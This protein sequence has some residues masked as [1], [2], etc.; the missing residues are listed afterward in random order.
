MSMNY[1]DAEQRRAEVAYRIALITRDYRRLL[2]PRRGRRARR[3][4]ADREN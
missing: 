4:G 3:R 2:P 1:L